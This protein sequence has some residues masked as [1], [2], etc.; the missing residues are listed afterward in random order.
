M[1]SWKTTFGGFLSA[2]GIT[3]SQSSDKVLGPIGA[4]LMAVGTLLIGY[5]A[6]DNSVSSEEA[7]AK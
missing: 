1:K 2:I 6:R 5:A 4:I 3:L 7:G